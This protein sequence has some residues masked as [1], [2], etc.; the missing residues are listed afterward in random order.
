MPTVCDW[1][2]PAGLR[3]LTAD[4]AARILRGTPAGKLPIEDPTT[5]ELVINL[6]AARALGIDLSFC[7]LAQVNSGIQ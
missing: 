6:K 3:R 2:H 1:L 4:F 5:V 7:L